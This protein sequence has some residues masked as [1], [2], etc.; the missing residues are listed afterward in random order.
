MKRNILLQCDSYKMSHWVQYPPGSDGYFGYIEA[1]GSTN[2]TEKTLFFGLQ[3]FIKE[4]LLTPFTQEDIYEAVGF[5]KAH[6]EPFNREGWQYILDAY[7]GYIPVV[8]KAAPEGSLIPLSNALVTVEC[9]DP[10]CFWVGSY[11]ETML[12]RAVWYPTTVAT[13]SYECKQVIKKYLEISSDDPAGQL[14]F[15]L[16][17]FGGRGVSSHESAMLGGAAHLVN[18]MGSDTIEGVRAANYYYNHSMAAFSIP[19]A[20]HSTITAWGKDREEDAYRNMLK[21]YGKP[22][23]LLAIVSDSYDIFNACENLW[24]DKLKQEVIDSGAL[25][26]IRPDS[27]DPATVVLKVIEILGE[28]FGFTYNKKDFKVLNNVR[29]IQGDG[30]NQESIR[31]ILSTLIV[32]QWSADNIAFGMG[33]ALLQKLDRD[34]FQF[35]MK[36]SAIRINGEWKDVSKSPV[37]DPGKNS[38]GGR[39][40]LYRK[41]GK[42]FTSDIMKQWD[43]NT[44]E[45]L[46]IVYDGTWLDNERIA[47]SHNPRLKKE[48]TFDEVR[49]NSN[50]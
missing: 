11:I 34:T 46:N 8:I 42:Y 15:K 2:G 44:I 4:Y 14:P 47:Y 39:L 17:D 22:N 23:A 25:V 43:D 13:N 5:A 36:C 31:L 9:T 18:F 26:I 28:R 49:D 30:I 32:H 21:Q 20:E 10:K 33:G 19:A 12:H 1:R 50:K 29:V 27:G 45:V 37:T 41:N 38:K 35:A 6:G 3:M 24:G 16:H 40:T 7:K 48:Y